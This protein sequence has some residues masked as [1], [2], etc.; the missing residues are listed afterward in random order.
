M[1]YNNKLNQNIAK[2]FRSFQ[3]WE[4]FPYGKFFEDDGAEVIFD[5]RYRP[6]CRVFPDGRVEGVNPSQWINFTD[7]NWFY[8]SG[9]HPRN[10]KS[11]RAALLSLIE[12]LGLSAELMVR[13]ELENVGHLPAHASR[14]WKP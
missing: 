14:E 2:L 12:Q 7:Q 6:I 11:T 8:H 13:R 4:I 10:D 5:R 9:N 1:A 3:Q